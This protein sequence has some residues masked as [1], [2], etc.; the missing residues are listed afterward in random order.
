[1]IVGKK[2]EIIALRNE[3]PTMS[4]AE[5]ARQLGISRERVRQILKKNELTTDVRIFQE[6]NHCVY[7]KIVIKNNKKYCSKE[8]RHLNYLITYTC[9]YC[10]AQKTVKKSQY[11]ASRRKSIHQFCSHTCNLNYYW[12]V[13]KGFIKRE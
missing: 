7:C 2:L 4:A 10:G 8:C 5:I 13:R 9:D 11:T 3:N 12:D 1:M 6:P